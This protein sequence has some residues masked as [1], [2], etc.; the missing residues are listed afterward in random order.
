MSDAGD[1]LCDVFSSVGKGGRAEGS[2][3][4]VVG[5]KKENVSVFPSFLSLK[6]FQDP[7]VAERFHIVAYAVK[8]IV[9]ERVAPVKGAENSPADALQCVPIF[10]VEQFMENDFFVGSCA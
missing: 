7:S 1:T 5:H 2:R 6:A 8:N 4:A 9:H 10:Q 3:I